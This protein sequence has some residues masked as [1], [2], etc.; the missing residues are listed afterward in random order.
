MPLFRSIKSRFGIT[1]AFVWDSLCRD[2]NNRLRKGKTPQAGQSDLGQGGEEGNLHFC[3]RL[4][5]RAVPGD[6]C[7][8][9]CPGCAAV[10]ALLLSRARP[11]GPGGVPAVPSLP[12]CPRAA[13][14]G[15]GCLS[16]VQLAGSWEGAGFSVPGVGTRAVC[17]ER[18]KRPRGCP[19]PGLL[20][21]EGWRPPRAAPALTA[22]LFCTARAPEQPPQPARRA[23]DR[24][25]LCQLRAWERQH[26]PEPRH[27][28]Q[29][30]DNWGQAAA[31]PADSRAGI[32]RTWAPAAPRPLTPPLQSL[33]TWLSLCESLQA[34]TD[35]QLSLCP[36]GFGNRTLC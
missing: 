10:R 23:R 24:E 5:G 16:C 36:G 9:C 28:F 8:I 25:H 15:T 11:G 29:C 26:Q 18:G 34:A 19:A 7:G 1:C 4:S 14:G 22:S 21:Q 33:H 31:A 12:A 35:P 2:G 13:E 3:A 17:P 30:R 27:R 6:P 20:G 32:S